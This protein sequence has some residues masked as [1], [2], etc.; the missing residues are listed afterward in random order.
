MAQLYRYNH[1]CVTKDFKNQILN[2]CN[3]EENMEY[4]CLV[5]QSVYKF[6]FV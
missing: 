3:V 6:L 1:I 2:N 4:P 5:N